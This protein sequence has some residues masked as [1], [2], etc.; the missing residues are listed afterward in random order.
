MSFALSAY[1]QAVNEPIVKVKAKEAF[2]KTGNGS[3]IT[4]VVE[5]KEEYHIQANKVND[6]NLVPTKLEFQPKDGFIIKSIDYPAAK[7]FKLD[8]TDASL[9]V[10]DGKFEIHT[11]FVTG[12]QLPTG[13]HTLDAKLSYQACNSKQCL[14]PR[15]VEFPVNIQ[16]Q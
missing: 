11:L 10:F 5:V 14:F 15:S 6:D 12:A 16:V 4:I 3:T 13:V 9:D 8:G 2:V 1:A 7:K